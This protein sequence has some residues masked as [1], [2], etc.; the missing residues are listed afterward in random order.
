MCISTDVLFSALVSVL[1]LPASK[2]RVYCYRYAISKYDMLLYSLYCR[3]QKCIRGGGHRV[4][5][6]K[7]SPKRDTFLAGKVVFSQP[8]R[9]RILIR[10]YWYR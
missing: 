10:M 6:D 8:Y 9:V 1:Y 5:T 4:Y 2:M 7:A 3:A